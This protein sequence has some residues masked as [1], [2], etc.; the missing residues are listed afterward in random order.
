[1]I[2][3]LSQS[4]LPPQ[5]HREPVHH[6]LGHTELLHPKHSVH[7]PGYC[8]YL[9]AQ[10]QNPGAF[11][12]KYPILTRTL[13]TLVAPCAK[14]RQSTHDG[15]GN[16]GPKCSQQEVPFCSWFVVVCARSDAG[17]EHSRPSSEDVYVRFGSSSGLF[18]AR[19][20]LPTKRGARYTKNIVKFLAWGLFCY[21]ELPAFLLLYFFVDLCSFLC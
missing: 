8:F 14:I 13:Y 1:M 10:A 5:S 2:H 3:T 20:C 19:G 12:Q 6:N 15:D 11:L 4:G 18:L 17:L 21:G 7:V 9:S 16:Q